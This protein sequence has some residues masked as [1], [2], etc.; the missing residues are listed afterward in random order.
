[1]VEVT[2]YLAFLLTLIVSLFPYVQKISKQDFRDLLKSYSQFS[3]IVGYLVKFFYIIKKPWNAF[4][5]L[6]LFAS[7]DFF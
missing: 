3:F 1:M 4:V 6:S 2:L 5:S 7:D